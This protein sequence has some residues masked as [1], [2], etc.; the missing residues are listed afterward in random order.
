MNK[1]INCTLLVDD[2]KYDNFYHERVL[3]RI[4]T[5]NNVVVKANG[6]EALDFLKAAAGEP[7]GFPNLIM[8]DINMPGI[9]G[10]EFL[11]EYTQIAATCKNQAIVLMLTTSIN[12]A[13]E[14]RAR[15]NEAVSDFLIKPLTYNVLQSTLAKYF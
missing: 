5:L 4:Y 14:A 10:W 2:V 11:A 1:V 13:D 3:R 9:N 12:P 8:V 7:C 6:L 15:E